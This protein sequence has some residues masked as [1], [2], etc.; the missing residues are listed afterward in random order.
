[1]LPPNVNP[2]IW[3]KDFELWLISPKDF[4]T[5]LYCP[6][7]VRLGLLEPFDNI[8]LQQWFLDCNSVIQA[9]FTES[10][11]YSECWQIFPD[12]GLI[13][14]AIFWALRPLFC[15]L[16]TIM[17]LSSALFFFFFFLL[18]V[19]QPYFSSRLISFLNVSK[20]YNP[21]YFW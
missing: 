6:V 16:V 9:S 7:F 15:K 10:S 21:L 1:M 18:L 3:S 2:P 11:P 13:V 14:P 5:P 8:L 19:Y 20:Q 17:K 12:I 4:I